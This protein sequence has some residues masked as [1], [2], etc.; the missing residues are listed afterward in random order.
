MMPKLSSLLDSAGVITL[1]WNLEIL[2][3]LALTSELPLH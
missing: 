2:Q 3:T 1:A